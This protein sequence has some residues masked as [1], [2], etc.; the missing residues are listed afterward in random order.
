MLMELK[1]VPIIPKFIIGK[2]LLGAKKKITLYKEG[3]SLVI[4]IMSRSS[5]Q[6]L[7]MGKIKKQNRANIFIIK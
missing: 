1:M 2:S 3:S 4:V 5:S 6:K 7:R